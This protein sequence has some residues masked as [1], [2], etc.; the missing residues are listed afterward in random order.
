MSLIDD[1]EELKGLFSNGLLDL[2]NIGG[3][4]L[5][6]LDDRVRTSGGELRPTL[7]RVSRNGNKEEFPFEIIGADEQWHGI[8][9]E[10]AS[11]FVASVILKE[12]LNSEEI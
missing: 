6:A 2:K 4:L 12:R 9:A 8:N 5:V 3:H 11:R 1:P 7:I 10:F